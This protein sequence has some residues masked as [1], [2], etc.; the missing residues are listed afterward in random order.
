MTRPSTSG[1]NRLRI[2]RRILGTQW[3]SAAGFGLVGAV[4]SGWTNPSRREEISATPDKPVVIVG[5]GIAGLAA[6]VELRAAGFRDVIVLE[7]RNRIG[8]RIW[9]SKIGDY[10]PIDLGASWVH[11][12]TG[13]PI[14][15]L[16]NK[17][18]IGMHP[19][20][21]ENATIHFRHTAEALQSYDEVLEEF[22]QVARQ[23]PHDSLSVVYERFVSK[24]SM[25]ISE[26][27][28]LAYVLS[29]S[30]E[31]EIGADISDL[32]L[33]NV[34]GGKDWP[35]HDALF[36]AG[37]GQIVD[38][39]A[40]NLDI[41]RGQAV[42]AIDYTG[43]DVVLHTVTDE[44]I[45]AASVIVTVPLGVLKKGTLTFTPP[46][47]QTVQ[48]AIDGLDMGVLN[49][50]CLLFEDIFWPSDVELIGYVNTDPGQWAE[51]ISM[52]PY[53][54]QPILVMFNAGTYAT[55][56]ETMTD[57]EV[58]DAALEALSDMYG[59]IPPPKDA[60][61]T[62]WR[63]DPWSYGSY[64]Y[65]PVG[66]TFEYHADLTKPI[67]GR[68]FLAG[69]ATH[70]EYPATVHGAFLSGVRAARLVSAGSD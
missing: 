39:L 33:A 65:V 46:L 35:G 2:N 30:I 61:I 36:P 63:S 11:G 43:S 41:R 23:R 56:T 69:E 1:L 52:Y 22:W 5:A 21:Y 18:S 62:R 24:S 28:F 16:A 55:Q 64:S 70:A 40:T 31:H 6:A 4:L 34:S 66:S 15:E 12:I 20:D 47:P 10:I 14:A 7:A 8:G 50:T 27:R 29:T 38:V 44:K 37:Y 13:N 68:V 59:S 45:E 67:Q 53:T 25:S 19:T 57:V 48:R 54:Q 51:T 42:K 17:H 49:K 26:R 3:L 32:S 60:L 58:V 9:T